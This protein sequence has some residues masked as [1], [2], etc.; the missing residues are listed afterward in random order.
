MLNIWVSNNLYKQFCG[1]HPG[2]TILKGSSLISCVSG[3]VGLVCSRPGALEVSESF[4][5]GLV[6]TIYTFALV[7]GRKEEIVLGVHSLDLAFSGLLCAENRYICFCPCGLQP[8]SRME[9]EKAESGVHAGQGSE[10]WWSLTGWVSNFPGCAP[11][12][13]DLFMSGARW[14]WV[15][16]ECAWILLHV[17][18]EG[19]FPPSE[20]TCHSEVVL[21]LHGNLEGGLWSKHQDWNLLQRATQIPALPSLQVLSMRANPYGTS[22]GWEVTFEHE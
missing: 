15:E 13:A 5:Q 9:A 6:G 12:P 7:P 18:S 19:V 21:P 16:G 17:G 14:P 3:R 10:P 4:A 22:G 8:Q 1:E 20:G 11:S 2:L